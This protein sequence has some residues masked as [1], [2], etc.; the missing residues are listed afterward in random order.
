VP[1]YLWCAALAVTSAYVGGYWDISW[2]RSIGRDTFWS[3]PHLAIYACGVLAGLSSAIVVVL[4]GNR[5]WSAEAS[6][7]DQYVYKPLQAA[8]A[9]DADGRLTLALHDPG[10]I[11]SRRI[12]DFVPDHDHLM[13]LFV[14]SPEL[15]RFWHLHPA[16]TA[17]GTFVQ[18]LPE[19]P[20]RQYE[21]FGD[22]VHA[23][24][25]S[26]TVTGTFSTGAIT[27][28]AL[29]GDDSTWSEPK[30]HDG[31][32]I[33][34]IDDNTPLVPKRLTLFTFRMNDAYGEPVDD[35][36]L[37]MGMP[38]HAI[39][40]KRDRR[41]FAHVHPSGS[42]PMAALQIAMPALTAAHAHH[43][44]GRP[45][46]VSFPYGFPEAGDYR[47]FVQMKRKGAVITAAFDT[48]VR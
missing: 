36:E 33:E 10:W 14:V 48:S 44:G 40:V 19:M 20:P 17:T 18:Q 24:G 29:M 1:W 39:F 23:T 21:L 22:L 45:A 32:R 25:V 2:H 31:S 38:G 30:V 8:P 4:L 5:W 7:Y 28:S 42:A 41:V 46:T 6:S 13:H 15:D 37:Y 16:E 26:E 35:L 43:P 9:L 34:W 47:I 3:A 11:G 12:D 27:G